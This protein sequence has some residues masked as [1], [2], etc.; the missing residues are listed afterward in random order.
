MKI[1]GNINEH[2]NEHHGFHT[3][4]IYMRKSCLVKYY[5]HLVILQGP[6]KIAKWDSFQSDAAQLKTKS[7]EKLKSDAGTIDEEWFL[8]S[9]ILK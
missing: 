3:D 5:K 7:R 1:N 9:Q 8:E 2:L 4:Y 6:V